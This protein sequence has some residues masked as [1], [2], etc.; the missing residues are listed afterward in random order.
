DQRG[1]ARNPSGPT[2][3]GSVQATVITITPPV[4]VFAPPLPPSPP[5]SP[6][7]GEL[8]QAVQDAFYYIAAQGNHIPLV[9]SA[10]EAATLAV[11]DNLVSSDPNPTNQAAIKTTFEDAVLLTED[12]VSIYGISLQAAEAFVLQFLIKFN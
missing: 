7:P 8:K 5:S 9:A 12:L 6:L 1:D 3:L 10:A 2:D 4:T 11:L